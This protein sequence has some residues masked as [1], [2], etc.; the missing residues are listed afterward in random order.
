MS[1]I[2]FG[3]TSGVALYSTIQMASMALTL[4]Y[5]AN[6][7]KVRW[8]L[9]RILYGAIL[10]VF[11]CATY[12][13]TLSIAVWKDPIFSSAI[14]LAALRLFD[15]IWRREHPSPQR[16]A[17]FAAIVLILSLFRSNGVVVSAFVCLA[18]TA[19][20]ALAR[21][22]RPVL[23][24][25]AVVTGLAVLVSLVLAGFVYHELGIADARPEESVGIPVSQMARVAALDGDMSSEDRE[26]MNSLLPLGRYKEAYRPACVDLLK[27][28]A[29]FDVTTLQSGLLIHWLSMFSKN[30]KVFFEAR[31]LQTFGFWALNVEIVNSYSNSIASGGPLIF[32]GKGQQT[33]E[34]L[35]LHMRSG[36]L[37]GQESGNAA[38]PSDGWF[39]PISWITWLMVVLVV[40][41]ISAR[42]KLLI[43]GVAPPIGLAISILLS[44]PIWYCPRYGAAEQFLLPAFLLL[45][46]SLVGGIRKSS[47]Q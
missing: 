8:R 2:G 14:A 23:F 18:L 33:A 7:C 25:A 21:N 1:S 26:F 41:C 3:I 9:E 46:M 6:W 36:E 34:K 20:S 24:P 32:S 13:A 17:S 30:P 42:K 12:F 28:D 39:V 35:C 40:L 31:E 10:I 38:L 29:D 11:G 37:P 22:F 4:S 19:A 5:C 45:L 16:L 43:L 44:S 27:W 15:L 47:E